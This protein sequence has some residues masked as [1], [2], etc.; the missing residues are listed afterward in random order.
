[1]REMRGMWY[2]RQERI[3]TTSTDYAALKI[4]ESFIDCRDAFEHISFDSELASK[5]RGLIN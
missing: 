1:M 2:N 4:F 3:T 5:L